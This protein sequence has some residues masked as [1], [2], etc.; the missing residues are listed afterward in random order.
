MWVLTYIKAR[1]AKLFGYTYLEIG[2]FPDESH[3]KEDY[4]KFEDF[5]GIKAVPKIMINP[6]PKSKWYRNDSDIVCFFEAYR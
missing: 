5:Q 2:E 6:V 1:V 4:L 3:L